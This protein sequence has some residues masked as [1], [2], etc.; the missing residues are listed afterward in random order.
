MF[1]RNEK[2]E[3]VLCVDVKVKACRFHNTACLN[4]KL[5]QDIFCAQAQAALQ[6]EHSTV[7]QQLDLVGG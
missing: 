7:C 4:K 1:V 6:H 2:G 3:N 5:F